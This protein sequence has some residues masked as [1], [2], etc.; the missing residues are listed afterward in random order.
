[1]A[2]NLQLRLLMEMELIALIYC[3]SELQKWELRTDGN[4][5]PQRNLYEKLAEIEA[6]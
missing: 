5:M 4:P 3:S 1:M 2:L 6:V